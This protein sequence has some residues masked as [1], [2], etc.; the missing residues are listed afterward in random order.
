L[1]EE[2]VKISETLSNFNIGGKIDV[3]KNIV[4]YVPLIQRAEEWR[5]AVL[6]CVHIT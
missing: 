6:N 5:N 1:R 3:R 4:G 2:G